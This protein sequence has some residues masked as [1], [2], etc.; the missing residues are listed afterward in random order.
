MYN[1][2]PIWKSGHYNVPNW[3]LSSSGQFVSYKVQSPIGQWV[4]ILYLRASTGGSCGREEG[5]SLI[6]RHWDQFRGGGKSE[7][8]E[9]FQ[10]SPNPWVFPASLEPPASPR[11]SPVWNSG[12]GSWSGPA[13][14]AGRGEGG[15]YCWQCTWEHSNWC[16][17]EIRFVGLNEERGRNKAWG[18]VLAGIK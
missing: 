4:I 12:W 5:E 10:R 6:T 15:E 13:A 8:A 2:E 7:P 9:S 11:L 14:G 3:K 16:W 17:T 18:W 1:A